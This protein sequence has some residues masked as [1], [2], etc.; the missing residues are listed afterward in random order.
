MAGHVLLVYR[1]NPLSTQ[2]RS[3]SSSA[4]VHAQTCLPLAFQRLISA[5]STATD[6]SLRRGASRLHT[7]EALSALQS[8][9][10]CQLRIMTTLCA[11]ECI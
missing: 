3:R 5:T 2:S 6:R 4:L 1:S 11:W 10:K 8:A 9:A 7:C